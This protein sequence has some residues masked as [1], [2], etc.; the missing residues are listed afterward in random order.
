MVIDNTII[1][2]EIADTFFCC[3][4]ESCRGACCIDGDAGAPLE[5]SEISE[6]EDFLERIKPYMTSEGIAVVEKNG[7]FDYDAD[8]CYVTPLIDDKD[9]VFVFDEDGIAR[10]AI[11][12]AFEDGKIEFQKPISCHLYPVRVKTHKEIDA[13][14]YHKWH[15]CKSAGILGKE[16]SITLVRFLKDPL[17]R[18]Y[19]K[20]WYAN[21]QK[22]S[23]Q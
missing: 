19:G 22:L 13:V 15:I 9:C 21:L 6:L 8:G 17:I 11:E 3:N 1:S 12:R 2:E 16:K 23:K 7:V 14:N 4:L 5:E 20:E 10:C 18:K